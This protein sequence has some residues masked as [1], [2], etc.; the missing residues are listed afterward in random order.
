MQDFAARHPAYVQKIVFAGGIFKGTLA[1]RSFVHFARLLNVFLPYEKM[2][3]LFSYLLMPRQRNQKARRLYQMQA[4]KLT[5]TEYLK[6]VGLYDEFFKL[7][8]R[9]FRRALFNSSL[10]I[11]GG[12]DFVFLRG[13]MEFRR[14]QPLA[15]LSILPK[16]GHICNIENPGAFNRLALD[17]LAQQTPIVQKSTSRAQYV[18]S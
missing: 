8:R 11:M 1:I 4:R 14:L 18:P 6:W 10:I 7:L 17:F 9:F 16:T 12:D 15:D 5:Q 2:Y 3:A 13:A